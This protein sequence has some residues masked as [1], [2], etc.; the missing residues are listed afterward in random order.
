MKQEEANGN[1]TFL[2]GLG[3]YP[4]CSHNHRMIKNDDGIMEYLCKGQQKCRHSNNNMVAESQKEK[5]E[6]PV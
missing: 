1:N 6:F 3:N 5:G 2:S 4:A